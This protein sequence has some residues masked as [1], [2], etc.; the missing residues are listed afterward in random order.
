MIPRPSNLRSFLISV[1][2]PVHFFF[3]LFGSP[4]PPKTP[5]PPCFAAT[6]F[7][8]A[9]L[10]RALYRPFQTRRLC[11]ASAIKYLSQ[12]HLS[13]PCRFFVP[14]QGAV[15]CM[16]LKLFSTFFN[17][18]ALCT[19]RF[20]AKLCG[21]AGP[22]FRFAKACSPLFSLFFTFYSSLPN[23]F[24]ESVHYDCRQLL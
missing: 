4:P 15:P 11:P 3:F 16:P 20:K 10:F 1:F 23:L 12:H 24:E 19:P 17:L 6:L 5:P 13:G 14:S 22:I 21:W 18:L 9:R 2:L 8:R 7:F